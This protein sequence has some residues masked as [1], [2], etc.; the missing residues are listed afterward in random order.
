VGPEQ[1]PNLR[2]GGDGLGGL[3]A[4]AELATIAD[5]CVAERR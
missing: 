1:V 3:G 5:A 2:D 4:V